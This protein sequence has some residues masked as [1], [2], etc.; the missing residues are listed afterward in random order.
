MSNSAHLIIKLDQEELLYVIDSI[1]TFGLILLARNFSG[2]PLRITAKGQLVECLPPSFDSDSFL[3][4]SSDD[5]PPN[6]RYIKF[7]FEEGLNKAYFIEKKEH[8]T[9]IHRPKCDKTWKLN[10]LV[11]MANDPMLSILDN[12]KYP[13]PGKL[14]E[15]L[16]LA[17]SNKNDVD[18]EIFNGLK[19]VLFLFI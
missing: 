1:K 16:Q 5:N 18:F 9:V 4:T 8:Q 6:F 2:K 13:I 7:R 3:I 14:F 17:L 10:E 11:P 19:T 12:P 15:I